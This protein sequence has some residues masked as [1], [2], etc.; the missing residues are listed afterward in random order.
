MIAWLVAAAWA[1]AT[2]TIAARAPAPLLGHP[3]LELRAGVSADPTGA[4]ASMCAGVTPVAWLSVE[5]CGSGAGFLYPSDAPDLA[6]LRA[7]ARVGSLRHGKLDLDG[8]VGLGVAEAE[9]ADDAP[10]LV[11]GRQ[12]GNPVETAGPEAALSVSGR[13]WLHPRAFAVVDLTGGAAWMAEAPAVVGSTTE[14]VPFVT[15]SAGAGF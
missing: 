6:H 8:F 2:D 5:A 14:L 10:G 11:F 4:G 3:V 12:G 7:R 15:L 9:R 13:A 1:D